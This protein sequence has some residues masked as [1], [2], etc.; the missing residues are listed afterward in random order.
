MKTEF[1][2]LVRNV[3]AMVGLDHTDQFIKH[4]TVE[5]FDHP[6][7]GILWVN[8]ARR[9]IR[10]KQTYQEFKEELALSRKGDSRVKV[11]E[12][13]FRSRWITSVWDKEEES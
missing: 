2:K 12:G 5:P 13:F 6:D 7:G 11:G 9:D 3:A 8:C 10:G 4:Q 1:N